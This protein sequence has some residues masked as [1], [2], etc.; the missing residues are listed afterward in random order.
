MHIYFQSFIILLPII[1]IV[2]AGVKTNT[3]CC[4]IMTDSSKLI[5]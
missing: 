4:I 5:M 2:T 1:I 3:I